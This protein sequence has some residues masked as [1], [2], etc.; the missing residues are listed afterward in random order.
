MCVQCWGKRMAFCDKSNTH[1]ANFYQYLSVPLYHTMWPY[2]QP[3]VL[4]RPSKNHLFWFLAMLHIITC[5]ITKTTCMSIQQAI[6][7][8]WK[9]PRRQAGRSVT[10]LHLLQD[11][12]CVLYSQW[13]KCPELIY[14]WGN[15]NTGTHLFYKQCPR[16]GRPG[17][18]TLLPLLHT[19]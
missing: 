8:G 3:G 9:L 18:R 11:K 7:V 16:Y 6:I 12:C 19:A 15:G 10:C 5:V 2:G 4:S 1:N 17:P 13:L 14:E